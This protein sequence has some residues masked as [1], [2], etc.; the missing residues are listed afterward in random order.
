MDRNVKLLDLALLREVSLEISHLHHDSS[1]AAEEVASDTAPLV[2]HMHYNVGV[3]RVVIALCRHGLRHLTD[4]F[5]DLVEVLC[6]C[7]C[8]GS[9]FEGDGVLSSRSSERG[10][11]SRR[12]GD[13]RLL[14]LLLLRCVYVVH[15]VVVHVLAEGGLAAGIVLLVQADA[16]ARRTASREVRLTRLLNWIRA[17]TGG[18]HKL[19]V[20]TEFLWSLGYR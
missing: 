16:V 19:L 17:E 20:I 18:D 6:R 12:L 1:H 3:F 13:E 9:F 8:F 15:D 11:T 4:Q 14:L 7:C 10:A 5:I 2:N